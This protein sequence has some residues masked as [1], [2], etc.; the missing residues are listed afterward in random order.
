M[1]MGSATWEIE[2]MQRLGRNL[3]IAR[4]RR[5]LTQAELAEKMT[6]A[7]GTVAAMEAGHGGTRIATI[8]AA[9]YILGLSGKL[10]SFL[11][12]DPEGELIEAT[13]GR[14]RARRVHDFS[15][16]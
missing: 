8:A 15:I 11:A 3:K 13:N 14:K 6:C 2:E 9:L 5:S 12:D 1:K 10:G 16:D 4:I 7:R